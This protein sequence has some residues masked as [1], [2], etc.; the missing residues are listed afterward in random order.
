MG[1]RGRIFDGATWEM[2]FIYE[3][4]IIF[5]YIYIYNIYIY[6]MYIETYIYICFGSLLAI[7]TRCDE[8]LIAQN[9]WIRSH[10]TGGFE[11]G[12]VSSTRCYLQ[13][14]RDLT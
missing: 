1:P 8:N 5:T 12:W 4:S 3:Y 2:V 9:E 11:K 7:A 13:K 6:I 10:A 14:I